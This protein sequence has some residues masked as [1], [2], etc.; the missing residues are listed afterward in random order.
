MSDYDENED[1]FDENKINEEIAS[2]DKRV[3]ADAIERL[4]QK[5]FFEGNPEKSLVYLATVADLRSE[6]EDH[7]GLMWTYNQMGYVESERAHFKEALDYYKQMIDQARKAMHTKGEIDGLSGCASMCRRMKRYNEAADF[8]KDAVALGIETD[9]RMLGHLKADLARMLR[10][11]GELEAAEQLLREAQEAFMQN[12]FENIVPRVENELASTLFDEANVE[13]S[14]AKA[15]E[16]YHLAKYD[17]NNREID[18][19]QFLMARCLNQLGRFSEA[20]KILEEMKARSTNRKRQKHR[21]RTDL[22]FARALVGLDRRREAS[23][24]LNVLIPVLKSHKL[25]FEACDAI[26][27]QGHNLIIVGELLEA[28]QTLV[29]AIAL[30]EEHDFDGFFV[31]ATTLLAICYEVMERHDDKVHQYEIVAANPL[32]MGRFEF[33]MA[34]GEIGLHYAKAGNSEVANRYISAI[35]DGPANLVTP[36][37][38]A[39]SEEAQYWLL[40]GQGQKIKAKNIANKA[41]VNYLLDSRTDDA[42]RLAQVLR[43]LD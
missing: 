6:L 8:L 39:Q 29:E 31:E 35:S 15:T 5:T 40:L 13:L 14:L 42:T 30:A 1:A 20:F 37:I 21:A 18:R 43:E 4:A 38:K 41:M 26:R 34:A 10:K 27:M 36:A 22:E 32:N 7:S 25:F 2:P 33:W 17:E 12:G 16:A 23:A 24:L 19:A 11:S 28:E 3:R 9:Y